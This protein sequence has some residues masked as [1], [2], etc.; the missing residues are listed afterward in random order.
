MQEKVD[1]E[2]NVSKVAKKM[3]KDNKDIVGEGAIKDKNGT[4]VVDGSKIM[5]VWS[6]YYEKLLNEE[7]DWSRDKLEKVDPVVGLAEEIKDWEVREAIAKSKCDKLQIP[8]V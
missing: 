1:E 8:Q 6:E 5:E 2:G 7:F 4:L 3:F